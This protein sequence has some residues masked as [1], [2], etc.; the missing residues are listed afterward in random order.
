LDA[1]WAIKCR[2]GRRVQE[3]TS[4]EVAFTFVLS[5]RSVGLF[6]MYIHKVFM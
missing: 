6:T 4:L 3:L 2:D 5:G 1:A